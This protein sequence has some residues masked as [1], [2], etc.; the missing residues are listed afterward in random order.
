MFD[1]KKARLLKNGGIQVHYMDVSAVKGPHETDKKFSHP[2]HQ[3]LIEAF[4]CLK[5]ALVKS[6]KL[7][8]VFSAIKAD[9]TTSEA[10]VEAA[11]TL[12]D[13]LKEFYSA[14]EA[15]LKVTGLH[16]SGEDSSAGVI[17]TGT[18]ES[19][20]KVIA[21]NTARIQFNQNLIGIESDLEEAVDLCVEEV[22]QYLHENKAGSRVPDQSELPFNDEDH[23]P[24]NDLDNGPGNEPDHEEGEAEPDKEEAVQEPLKAKAR[25]RK[26]ATKKPAKKAAKKSPKRK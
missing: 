23:G 9:L 11:N 22:R 25:P 16:L 21:I 3:D 10:E 6:M 19:D 7:D 15:N 8:W 17:V 18:F 2:V 12:R 26:P 24:G 4:A 5:I 14:L 13:R 1:L 20:K